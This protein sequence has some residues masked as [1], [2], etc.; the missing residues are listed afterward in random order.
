MLLI[1]FPKKIGNIYFHGSRNK[2]KIALTFDDD[3]SK[4]TEKILD[5]LKKEKI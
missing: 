5:I 3:P 4:E 2:N 1:K